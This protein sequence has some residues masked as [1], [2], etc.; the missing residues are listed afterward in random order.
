MSRVNFTTLQSTLKTAVDAIAA[1]AGSPLA[2]VT[3][4]VSTYEG[5]VPDKELTRL[6]YQIKEAL[7]VTGLCVVIGFPGS[8][9]RDDAENAVSFI[10]G[11]PTLE[12]HVNCTKLFATDGPKTDPHAIVD[13]LLPRLIGRPSVAGGMGGQKWHLAPAPVGKPVA[14][15]IPSLMIPIQVTLPLLY[16]T[17]N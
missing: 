7:A 11:M 8:S 16:R 13:Y 5:M 17:T 1:E 2:G 3:V 6:E 10:D 14:T 4:L 12:L 15:R 9:P